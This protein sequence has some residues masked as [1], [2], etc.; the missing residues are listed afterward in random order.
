MA[1]KNIFKAAKKYYHGNTTWQ[2]AIKK[3]RKECG[4]K[5]HSR[6]KIR[7]KVSGIKTNK[8][9]AD[10][11]RVNITVGSIAQHSS[12]LKKQ[13]EEKLAWLLF[14]RDQVTTKVGKRK[15]SKHIVE[16]RK[17]LRVL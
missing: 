11:K 7:R 13:L 2:Q 10:K 17:K 9:L 14:S 16:V 12:I 8:D 4:P 1:K 3:A 6:R 5:K 15:I